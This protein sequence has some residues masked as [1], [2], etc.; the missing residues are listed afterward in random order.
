MY[1]PWAKTQKMKCPTIYSF[2]HFQCAHLQQARPCV[3]HWGWYSQL[4]KHSPHPQGVCTL[5]RR[6]TPNNL[7]I[8]YKFWKAAWNKY[9]GYNE[10]TS[11][12]GKRA[13]SGDQEWWTIKQLFK[14][15]IC[16]WIFEDIGAYSWHSKWKL[17][18]N[19]YS[20]VSLLYKN[21]I[22][23]EK[24]VERYTKPVQGKMLAVERFMIPVFL[25]FSVFSKFS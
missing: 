17:Q 6:Q 9:L 23:T 22:Y 18:S 25:C 13:L 4:N 19:V 24:S 3:R 10:S 15:M 12:T 11:D 16:W 8:I 1:N 14:L 7:Q 5:V 21:D 2:I 20:S